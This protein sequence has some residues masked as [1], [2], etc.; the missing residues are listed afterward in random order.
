MEKNLNRVI[1][2][3]LNFLR[4][5]GQIIDDDEPNGKSLERQGLLIVGYYGSGKST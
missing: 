3:Q 5:L 4:P 1:I 2:P